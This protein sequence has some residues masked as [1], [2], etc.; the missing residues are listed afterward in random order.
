MTEVVAGTRPDV[1]IVTGGTVDDS[2]LLD[3]LAIKTNAYIIGVDRGL[4][5]LHRLDIKPDLI[6]GDFDSADD[7][8]R[9]IYAG[10]PDAIV[11]SPHKDLTDT[12]AA[13]REALKLNPACITLV[14]A[15]GTRIDHMLGNLALL[16]L[17]MDKGVEAVLVD[18]NNRIR[19]IDR[20]L[21]LKRNEQYGRYVSC[22]PFTR[23]VT[24]LSLTGFEYNLYHATIIKED[25]IGISNEI[26]EEE[27]LITLED[28]CLIV[29]ETSD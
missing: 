9:A 3:V 19:M 1:V 11:L 22:I 15:T 2:L 27:G 14:G 21:R 28:G 4:N 20:Q 16:K 29:L 5:A 17:C 7:G 24:G 6:I 8:I 25:T 18:K 26:R 12:H 23:Q 10:S 13:V